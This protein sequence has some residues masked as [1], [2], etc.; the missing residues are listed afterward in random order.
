MENQSIRRGTIAVLTLALG[1]GIFAACSSLPFAPPLSKPS[2]TSV[3]EG[4]TVRAF[5][6]VGDAE[7]FESEA[8]VGAE[9]PV[10]NDAGL[11]ERLRIALQELVKGPTEKERNEKLASIFSA[12]TAGL[13][14]KVVV[15]DGKARVDF[16]DFRMIIPKA[17]TSSGGISFQ[18]SL[19]LTVFQFPDIRQVSYS[20]EGSC[21]SYWEV[22]QVEVCRPIT[23]EAWDKAWNSL[24]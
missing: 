15:A 8:Y 16:R 20:I 14:K 19:N 3:S 4:D 17:G 21:A 11:E 23:R 18:F 22:L 24:D 10:P 1:A 13:V 12:E 9:R 2:P 6:T 5:F 7:P